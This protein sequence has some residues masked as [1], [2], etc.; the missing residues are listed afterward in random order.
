MAIVNEDCEP[1][2]H[3][4][5]DNSQQPLFRQYEKRWKNLKV[6]GVLDKVQKDLTTIQKEIC[7]LLPPDAILVGH[8]LSVDLHSLKV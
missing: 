8:N 1:V 2:Y 5:V 4:F 6:P 3:S 7:E